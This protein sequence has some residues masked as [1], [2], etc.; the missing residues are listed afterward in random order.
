MQKDIVIDE[1][2]Q[3]VVRG[4]KEAAMSAAEKYLSIGIDL[5][6]ALNEGLMKAVLEMGDRF[7]R[8]EIF[9]TELILSGEAMSA[10][11]EVL[12]PSMKSEELSKYKLGTVAI[13]TVQGDIHDI[14]KNIVATLL[15]AS[16][17]EVHDLGIDVPA[18]KYIEKA[19]DVHAQIIAASALLSTTRPF[20]RDIVTLLNDMKL[21]DKH[22]VMVGGAGVTP[23]WARDIGADGYGRDALDAVRMAKELA[24]ASG[25]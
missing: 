2:R 11:I 17:F 7:G 14:G 6:E 24:K 13:G 15:G 22:R 16:G 25:S 12:R 5:V 18:I 23:E 4:D 8:Q 1:L 21:R 9:L 20:Q 3:A 10:A 19:Q